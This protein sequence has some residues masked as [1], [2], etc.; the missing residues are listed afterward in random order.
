[1]ERRI[2]AQMLTC[3]DDLAEQHS[4]AP[5]PEG[6]PLQNKHVVVIGGALNS[7][8]CCDWQCCV[9]AG[10]WLVLHPWQEADPTFLLPVS[11]HQCM[12]FLKS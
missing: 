12:T 9:G 8:C 4:A 7:S 5:V 6:A 1:M 2:V 3:M 10:S 11:G